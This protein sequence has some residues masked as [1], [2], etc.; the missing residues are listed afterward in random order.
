MIRE[1]Q[2]KKNVNVVRIINKNS[3]SELCEEVVDFLNEF[4]RPDDLIS[5][6]FFESNHGEAIQENDKNSGGEGKKY[7]RNSSM[8]AFVDGDGPR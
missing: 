3:W 1:K 2:V 7:N 8:A 5:I 4:I 6:S